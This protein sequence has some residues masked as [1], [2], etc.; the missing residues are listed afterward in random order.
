MFS[1]S[2]RLFCTMPKHDC[3]PRISFHNCNYHFGET[4][5]HLASFLLQYFN[6]YC[7]NARVK[8]S[9]QQPAFLFGHSLCCASMIPSTP[10]T[11]RAWVG[12]Q[13]ADQAPAGHCFSQILPVDRPHSSHLKKLRHSVWKSFGLL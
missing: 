1:H 5:D 13:K 3:P 7:L 11:N 12:I 6:I 2:T 10:P 8:Y 9:T 4:N